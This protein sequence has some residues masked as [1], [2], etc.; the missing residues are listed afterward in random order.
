MSFFKEI[1]LT[2]REKTIKLMAETELLDKLH[3]NFKE[4]YEET[5]CLRFVKLK[6]IMYGWDIVLYYSNPK[7][8]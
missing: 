5:N 2:E 3:E 8:K 1:K 4:R 7:N 6:E